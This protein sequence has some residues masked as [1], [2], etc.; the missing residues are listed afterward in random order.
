MRA[1]IWLG[2]LCVPLVVVHSGL[3][4]GGLWTTVLAVNFGV[5]I[6]SGIV[7]LLLQ[8]WLPRKMTEEVAEETIY[9]QIGPVM[10]SHAIEMARMIDDVCG[11][12]PKNKPTAVERLGSDAQSE[13]APVYRSEVIQRS[14]RI[15][16]PVVT[17]RSVVDPIEGAEPMRT[18]FRE[19]AVDYLLKGSA[20]GSLLCSAAAS[21][22]RFRNLRD[23]LP[24]ATRPVV[25]QL[26]RQ[27]SRRRQLDRQSRL[28]FWLHSWILVHMPLSVSLLIL[29]VVHVI[30]AWRY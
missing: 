22:T 25:E 2:L 8:Q 15:R 28:H 14:G 12:P 21:E 29:L 27:C 4:L 6:V 24:A 13:A 18:F 9:S 10:R 16:G 3:R 1:H 19:E 23:G 20:S 7:G 5:V 30:S 17:T 11:L 26:E